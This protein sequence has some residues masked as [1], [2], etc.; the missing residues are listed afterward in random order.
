MPAPQSKTRLRVC[1]G[2]DLKK[3]NINLNDPEI[4]TE[5]TLA[6][7]PST[8]SYDAYDFYFNAKNTCQYSLALVYQAYYDPTGSTIL[9][10]PFPFLFFSS[11]S[12]IASIEG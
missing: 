7:P 6:K 11:I 9:A 2:L 8:P 1:S 5:L 12:H 4:S 3:E 10:F